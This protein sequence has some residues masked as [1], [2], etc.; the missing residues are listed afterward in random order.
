MRDFGSFLVRIW[1]TLVGRS[2]ANA[3]ACHSTIFTIYTSS[4]ILCH[5]NARAPPSRWKV[6][7]FSDDLIMVLIY[8]DLSKSV[9]NVLGILFQSLY[10]K[11]NSLLLELASFF[12][13]RP[14]DPGPWS[15]ILAI[16]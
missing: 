11:P 1:L 2:H 13:A 3:A 4:T 14:R 5:M 15:R 6:V 9:E 8:V 12:S 10:I 16:I 7:N